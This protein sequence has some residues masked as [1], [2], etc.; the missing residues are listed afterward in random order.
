MDQ[1]TRATRTVLVVDD[2]EEIRETYALGLMSFGYK[3]LTAKDGRAALTFLDE[4]LVH[5]VVTD[6]WMPG[7][8]GIGVATYVRA[9]PRLK[10]LP[11]VLVTATPL[12]EFSDVLV[13]DQYLEKPCS[14]D[15]IVGVVD[16]VCFPSP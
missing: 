11:V 10:H 15:D 9:N 16:K 14:L 7:M 12:Q 5:A 8:S 13:F 3:V 2:L 6:L 4:H 1:Q